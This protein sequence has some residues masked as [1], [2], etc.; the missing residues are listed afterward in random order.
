MEDVP[1]GPIGHVV[2]EEEIPNR[3]ERVTVEAD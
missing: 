2:V 1:E 3:R